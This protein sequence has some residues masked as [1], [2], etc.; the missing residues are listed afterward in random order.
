MCLHWLV[1]AVAPGLNRWATQFFG[2]GHLG[3]AQEWWNWWSDNQLKFSF[4]ALYI[5]GICDDLGV[6]NLKTLA[7][8]FWRRWR[9]LRRHSP[10][11][12]VGLV[13]SPSD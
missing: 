4:W 10:R 11:S 2:Q 3:A 6:P 5:A 8:F 7:R 13:E 1:D 9:R 12:S